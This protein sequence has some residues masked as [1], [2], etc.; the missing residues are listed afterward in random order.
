M[1]SSLLVIPLM[2]LGA[3]FAN[4]GLIS[5]YTSQSSF[6]SAVDAGYFQ[7]TFS[8]STAGFSLGYS[9]DGYAYTASDTFGLQTLYGWLQDTTSGD[10]ITI[11]FTSGTVTAIGGDFFAV[12]LGAA[13]SAGTVTLHFSDGKTETI[14][15]PASSTSF[16]G[17]TFNTPITSMT[18]TAATSLFAARWAA[19]DNFTVGMATPEPGSWTLLGAGMGLLVF[20]KLRHRKSGASETR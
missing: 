13:P 1:K 10:T 9:G 16:T 6:L 2:L 3:G 15:S 19:L 4:A 12:N 11:S 17:Y 7:E 20:A 14:A 8:T 18:I 5:A